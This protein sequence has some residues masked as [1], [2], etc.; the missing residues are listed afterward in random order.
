MI[1]LYVMDIRR[2]LKQQ[3]YFAALSLSLT[4]PDICGM[5]EYPDAGV[6]ERYINW[7]DKYLGPQLKDSTPT[8]C[9]TGEVVYNLRNTFLHQGTPTIDSGKV[10]EARN[11]MDRFMLILGDGTRLYSM[12]MTVQMR[13]VALRALWVDVTYLCD[14]LCE[15]AMAY[16]RAHQDAFALPFSVIPQAALYDRESPLDNIG[17]DPLGE[18]LLEKLG[19]EGRRLCFHQN[20]TQSVI[21]GAKRALSSEEPDPEPKPA[22]KETVK[23]TGKA[24]AGTDKNRE[25]HRLRCF[26]GEHFKET[27]Y[28]EK[29]DKIV[30]A[31]LSAKTKTQLN[32]NLTRLFPGKDVKIILERLKPLTADWPGQ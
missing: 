15:G 1:E 25:R 30:D 21:A 9:L 11:Q 10:K 6:T 18:M 2:A 4:L 32:A 20:V 24:R 27:R 31:V 8:P 13:D 26:F 17:G 23:P 14:T 5:V 28:K 19:T 29:R 3:C 16:Y 7:F 12:G 22:K